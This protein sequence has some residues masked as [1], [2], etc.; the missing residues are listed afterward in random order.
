MPL[1]ARRRRFGWLH[2]EPSRSE[3]LQEALRALDH[4][5]TIDVA[6]LAQVV[7]F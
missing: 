7:E 6:E 5:G 4:G 3:K 2:G 1:A